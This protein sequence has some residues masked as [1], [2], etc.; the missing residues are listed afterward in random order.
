MASTARR[1]VDYCESAQLT[2]ICRRSPYLRALQSCCWFPAPCRACHRQHLS[3]PKSLPLP[4]FHTRSTASRMVLSCGC[5]SECSARHSIFDVSG[6]FLNSILEVHP[7]F[8]TREASAVGH[9]NCGRFS[10]AV[11]FGGGTC[12]HTCAFKWQSG[13]NASERVPSSRHH[14]CGLPSIPGKRHSAWDSCYSGN[15]RE[16]W[17]H[18]AHKTR[19]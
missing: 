7:C 2:W 12:L 18:R 8:V 15:R 4:T 10:A 11:V 17:C 14:L 16:D 13:P 19:A 9:E 6:H 1:T 5:G 3:P